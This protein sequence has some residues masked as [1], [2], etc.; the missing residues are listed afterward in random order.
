MSNSEFISSIFLKKGHLAYVLFTSTVLSLSFFGYFSCKSLFVDLDSLVLFFLFLIASMSLVTLMSG[1]SSVLLARI[2][3]IN[4]REAFCQD[5]KSYFASIIILFILPLVV[6]YPGHSALSGYAKPFFIGVWVVCCICLK[7]V[8][9]ISEKN[10]QKV[11][12]WVDKN[13]IVIL[14]VILCVYILLFFGL[15]KL[16]YV[17]FGGF[18][19]DEAHFIQFFCNAKRG[20]YLT[21][22][23]VGESLLGVHLS[24]IMYIFLI[25]YLLWPSINTI[26]LLKV[27]MIGLSGVPLYFIIRKDHNSIV[28]ICILLSYLLFHHIAGANVFDFHEVIFA[29]FFLLFTYYFFNKG[30]FWLF[31]IFFLASLSIKENVGIVLFMFGVYALILGRNKAWVVVPAV[32]SSS[33][34]ILSLKVLLPYFGSE[35]RLYFQHI[36]YMERLLRMVEI[37]YRFADLISRRWLAL[38]YTFF[39]PVLLFIPLL[40][41]QF[42]FVLPWFLIKVLLEENPAIRTWHFMIVVGFLFIAY[43]DSLR[44]I[45]NVIKYRRCVI[46]ISVLGLFTSISC[47]PYWFRPEEYIAKSYIEAQRQ[48][49]E[50]IPAEASVC[51]PEYMLP[52]LADRRRLYNEMTFQ[53]EIRKDIDFI[54]FD[55]N[56]EGY[57]KGG[58]DITPQF[59][60]NLRE[61]A[62]R[63]KSYQDYEYFWE[64]DGIFIYKNK[65]YRFQW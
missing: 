15:T 51:A 65:S 11:V 41:L 18:M 37:P 32:I 57:R 47:F 2:K 26:L 40:S 43:A 48:T 38:I 19:T 23:V 60:I 39:Q 33:W 31:L 17:N 14:I 53:R 6:L 54:I 44:K 20:F 64:R 61:L 4:L 24:F 27:T 35:K 21:E 59:I 25:P 34:V 10:M 29:P 1:I 8:L 56:V 22:T 62:Y 52:Y 13:V 42:M 7:A 63:Q 3:K 28:V 36:V 46:A 49:L 55:S 30:N 9:S 50:L 12:G 58:R 5:S 16:K 45:G